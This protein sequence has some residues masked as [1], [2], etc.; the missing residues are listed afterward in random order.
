MARASI[1]LNIPKCAD[2]A[3]SRFV[4]LNYYVLR[5]NSRFFVCDII[6]CR[7]VKPMWIYFDNCC[8]N[9][10]FDELKTNIEHMECEA[11]LTILDMCDTIKNWNYLSSDVLLDEILE[12]P[13]IIKREKLLLLLYSS[14]KHVNFTQAIYS[15]AK[16]LEMFNIKS[17]DALHLASAEASKADVL[18]TTDRRFLNSS[19]KANSF[20]PVKNPLKWLTEVLYDRKP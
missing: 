7:K 9:R 10:P 16:E 6:W 19:A 2:Y 15:R 3:Q 5:Q 13:D 18:L 14:F 20:I 11:I 12:T 1:A 4:S 17:Y 8:L